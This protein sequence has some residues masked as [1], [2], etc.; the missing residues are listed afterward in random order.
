MFNDIIDLIY[1]V[2]VFKD[3]RLL[4]KH[5]CAKGQENEI[6]QLCNNYLINFHNQFPDNVI[7]ITCY[8][9]T[10]NTYIYSINSID[11]L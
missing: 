1:E 5:Y 7:S 6:K 2:K 9:N 10:K 4:R 3:N 11:D 8:D